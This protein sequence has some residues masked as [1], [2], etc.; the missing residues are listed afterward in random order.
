M[1]ISNE[2]NR[3]RSTVE[4]FNAYHCIRSYFVDLSIEDLRGIAS[5]YGITVPA[6]DVSEV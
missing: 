3:G 1:L 2:M 5:Q 4:S 6:C